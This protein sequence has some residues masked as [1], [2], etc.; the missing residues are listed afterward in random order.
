MFLCRSGIRY[1]AFYFL[2]LLVAATTHLIAV[3]S[4]L[5]F[6]QIESD[7]ELA[8]SASFDG[9]K[10][11]ITPDIE[12]VGGAIW[13]SHPLS[14]SEDL[15]LR[16]KIYLGNKDDDGADGIVFVIAKDTNS[17]NLGEGLGY[18]GIMP[19]FGIEID[20]YPN[21]GEHIGGD[22]GDPPNDHMGIVYGGNVNHRSLGFDALEIGN[23]EDGNEH[24]I[25]IAWNATTKKFDV[26]F[27]NFDT[28]RLTLTDD[29]AGKFIG[30]KDSVLFGITGSTGAFS[31][32]QYVVPLD[33][34]PG[35]PMAD[36]ENEINIITPPL[37]AP[38][39]LLGNS[40]DDWTLA[41]AAFTDEGKLILTPDAEGLVGAAW[42]SKK[43]NLEKNFDLEF[44]VFLGTKDEYGADGIVFVL[45]LAP[46]TADLGEGIGYQ[47]IAPSF[48]LELDTY[49]NNGE[50]LGSDLGD[51]IDD[52]LS[53]VYG[54]VLNHDELTAVV[55]QLG[56]IED[57]FEH[58][59]RVTWNAE[60]GNLSVYLDDM[61]YAKINLLSDISSNYLGGTQNVV[62]GFTASTGTFCN[63]QYI[64]PINMSACLAAQ[65]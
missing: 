39:E 60:G 46:I 11:V 27:D 5:A 42:Y 44:N 64:I 33:I 14:L 29:I 8:G 38:T 43:I 20:T 15:D 21:D 2:I 3:H 58:R 26:Y 9:E 36:E 28:P 37:E 35:T 41:E 51:P 19:S 57:G 10:L 6:A 12:N 59:L 7:W 48:G 40:L 24:I 62:F 4:D 16:F 47:G 13:Y 1:F 56:D 50:N 34:K 18:Q 65:E 54:G 23:V 63:L 25:R 30:S 53:V 61:K 45:A 17:T 55:K 52:H 31:N 49:P 22:Q 32:L